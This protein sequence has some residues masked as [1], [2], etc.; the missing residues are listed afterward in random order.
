MSPHQMAG[1]VMIL[2]SIILMNPQLR[3][4]PYAK[5]HRI[6]GDIYSIAHVVSLYGSMGFLIKHTFHTGPIPKTFPENI[7]ASI[8]HGGVYGGSIFTFVLWAYW[9]LGASSLTMGVYHIMRGEAT[10][11]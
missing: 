7:E 9:A 5:W 3:Y 1:G 6:A 10:K 11:P 4:G 8:S 2:C